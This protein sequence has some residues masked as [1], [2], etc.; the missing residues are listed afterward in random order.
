M[1]QVS[2]KLGRQ[3]ADQLQVAVVILAALLSIQAIETEAGT[4]MVFVMTRRRDIAFGAEHRLQRL[5][6]AGGRQLGDLAADGLEWQ[7]GGLGKALAVVGRADNGDAGPG[8]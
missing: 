4:H 6:A 1:L 2:G 5:A 7:F 3:L 8:Q